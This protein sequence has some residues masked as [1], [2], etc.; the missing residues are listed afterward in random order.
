MHSYLVEKDLKSVKVS[1]V[2]ALMKKGYTLLDVR[3]EKDYKKGHAKGAVN[4]PLFRPVTRENS[5]SQIKKVVSFLMAMTATGKKVTKRK[6][7]MLNFVLERN[8]EFTK[9]VAELVPRKSKIIVMCNRGF[10]IFGVM[11]RKILG[12]T[13]ETVIVGPGEN[14]KTCKDPDRAFG[15]E[16][17]SLKAIYELFQV[18]LSLDCFQNFI[19]DDRMDLKIFFIWKVELVNGVTTEWRWNLL[20][21]FFRFRS[22]IFSAQTFSLFLFFKSHFKERFYQTKSILKLDCSQ[23]RLESF[24]F[25]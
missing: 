22:K 3:L 24:R 12:G 15:R 17:R 25:P 11:E 1:E 7:G 13:L 4:V 23:R 8:T 21:N 20:R 5:W 16:T 14:P 19:C 6:E 10:F 2:E 18:L 9:Q